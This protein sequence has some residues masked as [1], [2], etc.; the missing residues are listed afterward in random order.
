MNIS[1]EQVP[2]GSC[3]I[4]RGRLVD[5]N[6]TSPEKKYIVNTSTVRNDA[7]PAGCEII[8]VESY[9]PVNCGN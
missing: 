4:I 2:E 5:I 6:G 3:I 8:L 1:V 7:Y 9:T